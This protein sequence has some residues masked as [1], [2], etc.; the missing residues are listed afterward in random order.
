[1]CSLSQTSLT[2][3]LT[4]LATSLQLRDRLW[5]VVVTLP[6]TSEVTTT[7]QEKLPG[8][9]IIENATW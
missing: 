8:E 5:E 2:Q 7:E 4:S 1:M 6:T 3:E 9:Y